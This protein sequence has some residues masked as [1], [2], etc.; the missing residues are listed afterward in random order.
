MRVLFCSQAAHTGGG[1]E[2]WM[3]ALTAGLEARGVEVFTALARGRFH[4]P[5]RYAAHHRV[6]NP[7]AVDGSTGFRETR[8][9]NLLRVFDRV[10]PDVV[11][12]VNLADALLAA[13]YAKTRGASHRI[14]V[15]IHGQGEDR[16]EQVRDCE[17]FIDLATSVSKRVANRIGGQHI[18][19]GVPPPLAQPEPR[20]HIA[21][22]AYVGRL[23]HDKRILDAIGLL[24]ALEGS[25]V[26]FHIA[27]SGPAEAAL[28]D[29]PFV[30]HGELS[31][32]ELYESF[33]PAMDALVVFSEAEAGP[34]VAWEAMIHGVVPVVSDFVG[35]AEEN[36]IRDVVFPVGDVEAA[37]R[38]IRRLT[39][40]GALTELS[41]RAQIELPPAYT[42]AVF[43]QTWHDALVQC[44]AS[45]ARRGSR[46]ELPQLISPG[47]L[48]RLGLG[49]ESMAALRRLLGQ[50]YEH[51][52]PGSE[53][54][55]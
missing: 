37:A 45:P 12:P 33:Y 3:E 13:S 42:L 17:S 6:A 53:W 36:V 46:S 55:H 48:A 29:M 7:I 35:R 23:D 54:P 40:P 18:P 28:R 50:T 9:A 19:T 14:A 52:D 21:H 2:A 15:C 8:I 49:V 27:G 5:D 20:D 30:F 38:A 47:R 31:R 51:L 25:R 32:R 11:I 34:I 24:R 22:L 44:A 16:I 41:R 39:A 1:V 43:E 26:T 4:D 10:K